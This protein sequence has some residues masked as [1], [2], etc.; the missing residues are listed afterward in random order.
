MTSRTHIRFHVKRDTR[1]LRRHCAG[2]FSLMEMVLVVVI[3]G[4]LTA[5]ALPRYSGTITN[6]R[7]ESAA[8]RIANDL[9]MVQRRARIQGLAHTITFYPS[10]ESYIVSGMPDPDKPAQSYT[11]K[12]SLDPYEVDVTSAVFGVD[13]VVVVDGYGAFDSTGSVVLQC[14]D[15]IKTVTVNSK[16]E[17]IVN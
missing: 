2:A 9:K 6:F 11:V 12:L 17:I 8:Q 3:I 16:H 14:G 13:A 1:I 4:I 5:V 15:R 7:A 10:T